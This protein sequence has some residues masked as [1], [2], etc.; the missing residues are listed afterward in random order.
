MVYHRNYIEIQVNV[1]NVNPSDSS[2]IFKLFQN[3]ICRDIQLTGV[4]EKNIKM[5]SVKLCLNIAR[6]FVLNI[7]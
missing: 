2:V 4:G 7:Q 6:A 5:K 3:E 1:N